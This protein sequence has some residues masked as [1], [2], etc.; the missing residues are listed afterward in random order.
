LPKTLLLLNLK[1]TAVVN[2]IEEAVDAKSYECHT[3]N[4]R[5]EI[6]PKDGANARLCKKQVSQSAR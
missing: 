4:A 6:S 5:L 2:S 1:Q 3:L